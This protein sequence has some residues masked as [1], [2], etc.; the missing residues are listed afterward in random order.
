[1][2]GLA[3]VGVTTGKCRRRRCRARASAVA[4]EVAEVIHHHRVAQVGEILASDLL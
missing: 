3:L 1:M 2:G 4:A